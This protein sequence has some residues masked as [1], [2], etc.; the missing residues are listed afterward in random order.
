[1][2]ILGNPIR[3]IPAQAQRSLYLTFDDG[4]DRNATPAI[5]DVLAR[6]G[7]RA[8][9]FLIAQR[10]AEDPATTRSILQGGHTIG[11]HSWDHRYHHF[12]RGRRHVRDWAARAERALEDLTGQPTAGF[13]PPAGVRTPELA[14]ALR[15][16]D[17]PLVL[18]R[19]RFFDS[20]IPWRVL[21]ARGSLRITP[22]GSLVLLHDRHDGGGHLSFLRTL[23][24]YLTAARERGYAFAALDRRLY[25]SP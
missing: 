5:L 7:A 16:L 9:F 19:M 17:L 11:N 15:E 18:W 13:R 8:T 10:A 4:P 12:F 6:H 3:R 23:D 2:G 21:W 14:W 25:P 1:M 24:G 22:P 20:T